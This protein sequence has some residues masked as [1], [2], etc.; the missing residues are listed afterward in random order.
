MATIANQIK[1]I[2]DSR[3]TLREKGIA[4]GLYVP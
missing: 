1:R 3:D 4:L 2:A